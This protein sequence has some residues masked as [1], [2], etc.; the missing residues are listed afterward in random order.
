MFALDQRV[1]LLNKTCEEAMSQQFNPVKGSI[2]T[3][4][5]ILIFSVTMSEMVLSLSTQAEQLEDIHPKKLAKGISAIS[6][7]QNTPMELLILGYGAMMGWL[8]YRALKLKSRVFSAIIA[9][10]FILTMLA[11]GLMIFF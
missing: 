4:L 2:S 8:I 7:F 9:G 6:A 11:V 5:E 10:I 1:R 3:R